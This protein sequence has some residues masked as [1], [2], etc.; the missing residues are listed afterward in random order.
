MTLPFYTASSTFSDITFSE[1]AP[2]QSSV[3]TDFDWAGR[4]T[5]TRLLAAGGAPFFN[6]TTSYTLWD[7]TVVDPR[8]YSSLYRSDAFGRLARVVL[9]PL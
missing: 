5:R 9:P 3:H 2:A 6:T 7:R 8:G 4:T 1:T